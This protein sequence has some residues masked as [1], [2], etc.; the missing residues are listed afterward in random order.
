MGCRRRPRQGEHGVK[1]RQA[2]GLGGD[3]TPQL[4][5]DGHQGRGADVAA[6]PA[7]VGA[8]EHQRAFV[9]SPPGA[10]AQRHVVGHKVRTQ[11]DVQ[12]GVPAGR[13]G[14]PPAPG[15]RQAEVSGRT[16][17]ARGGSCRE[18]VRRRVGDSLAECDAWTLGRRRS[19]R[20][21]SRGRV[22]VAV[23]LRAS[24]HAGRPF[25]PR[26]PPA[27]SADPRRWQSHAKRI[28]LPLPSHPQP[29]FS[30]AVPRHRGQPRRQSS[31][32]SASAAERKRGRF[33]LMARSQSRHA[34]GRRPPGAPAPAP[35][36]NRR[37]LTPGGWYRTDFFTLETRSQSEQGGG[38]C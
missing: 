13:D 4:G 32:A 26:R 35:A 27:R 3:E 8:G 29:P 36:P 23:C 38:G 30:P 10:G 9:G 24:A 20:L 33:T 15:A 21:R 34:S 37:S 14:Q 31:S 19:V 18:G 1:R 6:L 25:H 17:L 5:H 2:G 28:A 16:Y 11:L 12:H 7:H 22:G